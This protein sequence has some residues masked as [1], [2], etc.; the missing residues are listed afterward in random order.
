MPS[1]DDLAVFKKSSWLHWPL[2]PVSRFIAGKFASTK[3]ELNGQFTEASRN[4][5]IAA[6]GLLRIGFTHPIKV[7]PVA[8]TITHWAMTYF[9]AQKKL[10][11]EDQWL[12]YTEEDHQVP[13]KPEYDTFYSYM[14]SQISV[15]IDEVVRVA[16]Y[17]Q[18]SKLAKLCRNL[19][20]EGN[21]AYTAFPSRMYRPTEHNRL[22]LKVVQYLDEPLNCCPSLHIAYSVALYN[23][24]KNVLDFPNKS[25]E[26][27]QDLET[28]AIGMFDS[29][30]YTKQHSFIDVAVGMLAAEIVFRRTYPGVA[31]ADFTELLDRMGKT[32][33]EIPYE[34]IK[35]IHSRARELYGIHGSLVHCVGA[36]FEEMNIPKVKGTRAVKVYDNMISTWAA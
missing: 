8:G 6:E 3:E 22:S 7:L 27:W 35:E 17:G 30:M 4:V 26:F 16:P 9:T 25:P 33:T 29:V 1:I 14:V 34:R 20:R 2:Y 32:N 11:K 36:L 21:K 23:V 18:V 10:K 13:F 5:E 15:L 12:I 31:F 28:A 19:N 24:S